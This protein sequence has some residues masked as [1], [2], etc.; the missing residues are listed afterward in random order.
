MIYSN[1]QLH[2]QKVVIFSLNVLVLKIEKQ[3]VPVRLLLIFW[4]LFWCGS[5]LY[6]AWSNHVMRW[7]FQGR[8]SLWA[9]S[10]PTAAAA[11]T[12]H[13]QRQQPENWEAWHWHPTPKPNTSNH[14]NTEHWTKSAILRYKR[15]F[16]KQSL[17]N[18]LH[19]NQL[20]HECFH[21]QRTLKS[22]EVNK[23]L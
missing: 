15:S 14:Q 2:V 21:F 19:Y 3:K 1:Y 18:S 8:S 16:K 10:T 11:A 17:F 13:R 12:S 5:E 9:G 6:A 20:Q 22:Q 4:G 23:H 7:G